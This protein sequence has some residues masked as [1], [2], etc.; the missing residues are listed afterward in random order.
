MFNTL[1]PQL[2]PFSANRVSLCMTS[3]GIFVKYISQIYLRSFLF[4]LACPK[5]SGKFHSCNFMNDD[6][7]AAKIETCV[8]G[9]VMYTTIGVA[10]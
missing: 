8:Q 5:S 1:K 2:M 4:I 3:L 10:F 6:C 9:L 7:G